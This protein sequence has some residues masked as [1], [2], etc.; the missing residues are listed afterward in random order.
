MK[1]KLYL[2]LFTAVA[3]ITTHQLKAQ[4]AKGSHLLGGSISFSSNKSSTYSDDFKNKNASFYV[5]PAYG[6]FIKQNLAF[7]GEL[8]Y[9]NEHTSNT[10]P[11]RLEQTDKDNYYGVGVF[12]RQYK[13]LGSS[14]FYLFLQSRL[15]ANLSKGTSQYMN[16]YDKTDSKGYTV[17]LNLSPGIAYAITPRFHIETGL[18]NLLYAGYQHTEFKA[19]GSTQS[20]NSKSS[21]FSAGASVGTSMQ[22]TIGFRVLLVK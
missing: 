22:W 12:L 2:F 13:N 21:G 5:S 4:I 20:Y 19:T 14:G 7:G 15:G 10:A 6:K 11:G 1:R 9:G 18:N 17:N 8:Y 3:S 16:G